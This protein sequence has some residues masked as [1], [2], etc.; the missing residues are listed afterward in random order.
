[1]EN[2]DEEDIVAE[3]RHLI[4]DLIILGADPH[5]ISF[6]SCTPFL[7]LLCVFFRIWYHAQFSLPELFDVAPKIPDQLEFGSGNYKPEK[8][9]EIAW[10]LHIWLQCLQDSGIDL[11]E[12]GR[13]ETE[14]HEQGLV[15]WSGGPFGF[16]DYL[17]WSLTNLTY[18]PTLG[19]W[20]LSIELSYEELPESPGNMRGDMP[21]GW[22]EDDE[23]EKDEEFSVEEEVGQIEEQQD[24]GYEEGRVEEEGPQRP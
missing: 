12:Y 1:M 7:Q 18:G 22:I 9:W 13:E 17:S 4:E 23:N 10:L 5:V 16:T 20:N 15:S 14:L 11:E 21:G 8:R 19:E 3:W 24:I 2:V 6:D